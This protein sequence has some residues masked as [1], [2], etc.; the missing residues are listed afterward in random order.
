[1]LRFQVVQAKVLTHEKNMLTKMER[2]TAEYDEVT[3]QCEATAITFQKWGKDH[4]LL[5]KEIDLQE[6][7]T[8][9]TKPEADN[10]PKG[11][12]C[13]MTSLVTP[14]EINRLEG[15]ENN[16]VDFSNPP[17][18]LDLTPLDLTKF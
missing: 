17:T 16:K 11:H 14:E 7:Y 9:A 13:K 5:L 12:A 10:L 1:M 8:I 6:M 15:M 2:F 18:G 3:Q 4:G